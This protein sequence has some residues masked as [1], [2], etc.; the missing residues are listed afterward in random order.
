[1][2]KKII[3]IMASLGS[4]L[5]TQASAL[6][7]IQKEKI[8]IAYEVGK[9]IKAKD[10]MTFE[11]T[12]PSIMGQESSWGTNNLGDKWDKNGRLKSLYDSSLG[13]FQIKLSTA[14][15]T[16]NM[17]PELKKKYGYLVNNGKSTYK[18]YQKHREKLYYYKSIIESKVWN[19]RVSEGNKKAISTMKWAKKEFLYH[20]IFFTKFKK[21]ADQDTKLINKLMYDFKFGAIISGHYLKH[22]YEMSLKKFGKSEA[23]WKAVGRYNG[24]WSNRTYHKK[25][26]DRMKT[27]KK[28]IKEAKI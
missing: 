15:I 10:G 14:K 27:V 16:I 2:F 4:I 24:G 12:L 13:N 5:S 21:Q 1:M 11:N 8:K 19:K 25:I 7:D 22:C 18:E 6:S 20:H 26:L 23:Y 28:I 9:T 3:L 17:Y